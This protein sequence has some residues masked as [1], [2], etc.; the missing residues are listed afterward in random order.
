M[1]PERKVL[2]MAASQ[3]QG[4]HSAVGGEI[5]AVLGISFPISMEKLE[6]KAKSEG[7]DPNELWPWLAPMRARKTA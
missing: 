5:A 2:F 3:F 7:L 6:R 4:G 1:T